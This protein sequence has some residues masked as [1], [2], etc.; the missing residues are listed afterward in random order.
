M[1]DTARAVDLLAQVWQATRLEP[2]RA[3]AC[4]LL[5][6]VLWMHQGDGLW[7]N[8]VSDWSGR[9]NAGGITSAGG[10]NFWQARALSAAVSGVTILGE[11]RARPFAVAGFS[12]ARA[13]PVPPDVR[14]LHVL[15]LERWQAGGNEH[16]AL[17][18]LDRWAA[19]IAAVRRGAMLM[20]S[21]AER[22]HPH[23]WGHLQEA[24]LVAASRMLPRPD[25]IEVAEASAMAVFESAIE[26]GFEFPRTQ[27]YDVQTAICVMDAL[28]TATGKRRY[29]ELAGLGRAWFSGRNP[30]RAALYDRVNGRIADGIDGAVVSG[31]SGAE[32][33]VAGGLALLDEA[34]A[35]ASRLTASAAT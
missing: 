34:V 16:T 13:G 21:P 24:A 4:G 26:S 2:I 33:N 29:G 12:A 1:D 14:S 15:A 22:G 6:F 11:E 18:D 27:P 35:S 8:F 5:D 31:N 25:L 23:F 20:N 7:L 19:E 9:L 32:S 3:W 10:I 30:A 28:A 17:S